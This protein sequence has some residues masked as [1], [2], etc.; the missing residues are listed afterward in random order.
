MED[1]HAHACSEHA[2]GRELS[3][4]E[5]QQFVMDG[6]LALPPSPLVPPSA[7]A[8]IAKQVLDCG[9]QPAGGLSIQKRL[10]THR[11]RAPALVLATRLRTSNLSCG[12]LCISRYLSLSLSTFLS[13]SLSRSRSPLRLFCWGSY[14]PLHSVN[15]PPLGR[16]AR[17]LRARDA[18]WRCRGQ[19]SAARVSRAQRR[20][21]A[22]IAAS[23]RSTELAFGGEQQT[24]TRT[25]PSLH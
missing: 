14:M 21:A 13:L 15:P 10:T 23:A 19:Q 5:V 2:Q 11:A 9:Q 24:K 12:H 4:A 22:A 17:P 18:R 8:A 6:Y 25:P 3:E 1:A 16:H 7:H 20:R